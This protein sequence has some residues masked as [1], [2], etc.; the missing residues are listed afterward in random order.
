[1]RKLH[2]N[3]S[4]SRFLDAEVLQRELLNVLGRH[5]DRVTLL[6]LSS[7]HHYEGILEGRRFHKGILSVLL[8]PS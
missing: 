3:Q 2:Q 1:M 7:P 8:S 4:E 5:E 6:I